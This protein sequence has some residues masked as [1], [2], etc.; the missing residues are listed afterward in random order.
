MTPE[1]QKSLDALVA[2]MQ[3]MANAHIQILA[4]MSA[5]KPA[6]DP[7]TT[8]VEHGKIIG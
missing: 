2:A 6:P 3:I 5:P 8:Q 4:G 1:Q 7:Q